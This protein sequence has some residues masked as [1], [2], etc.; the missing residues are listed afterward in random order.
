MNKVIGIVML[1]SVIGAELYGFAQWMA[2]ANATSSYAEAPL[3]A[4]ARG[5]K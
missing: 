3:G 2:P 1:L 5:N 4:L